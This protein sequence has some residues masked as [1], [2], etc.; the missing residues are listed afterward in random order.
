MNIFFQINCPTENHTVTARDIISSFLVKGSERV[1]ALP[2]H[3]FIHPLFRVYDLFVENSGCV[4]TLG[5]YCISHA[6]I[7][8]IGAR[9]NIFN[10]LGIVGKRLF[11][12]FLNVLI[13]PVYYRH[14]GMVYQSSKNQLVKFLLKFPLFLSFHAT[15]RFIIF[16]NWVLHLAKLWWIFSPY[17]NPNLTANEQYDLNMTS[18]LFHTSILLITSLPEWKYIKLHFSS[19]KVN[20]I[21]MHIQSKYTKNES[22]RR[23]TH[24]L[25][26]K[27][28]FDASSEGLS[29]GIS[30]N[31]AD[32][33]KKYVCFYTSA[34]IKTIHDKI[35]RTTLRA[36]PPIL[37]IYHSVDV[38]CF[39][40][41]KLANF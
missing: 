8:V 27:T 15:T 39:I 32:K 38:A 22:I 21:F 36:P 14:I 4:H 23:S 31:R 11:F 20:Y 16:Q 10:L 40:L 3:V 28:E 12:I 7:I 18:N 26:D 13:H 37:F 29:S 30:Y 25:G 5:S 24:K 19:D 34:Y 17:P 1:M 6:S 33:R 35:P 41:E 2:L 9:G